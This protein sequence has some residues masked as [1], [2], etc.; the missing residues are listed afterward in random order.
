MSALDLGRMS[1]SHVRA[2]G[3]PKRVFETETAALGEAL[4]IE[5]RSGQTLTPYLCWQ[6]P[7]HWHLGKNRP[8]VAA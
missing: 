4:A 1:R 6:R 2:D 3:M 7:D 5:L 8:E